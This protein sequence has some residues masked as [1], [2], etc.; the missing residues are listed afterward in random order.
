[1]VRLHIT[2]ALVWHRMCT[3]TQLQLLVQLGTPVR[4]PP[5]APGIVSPLLGSIYRRGQSLSWKQIGSDLDSSMHLLLD[6]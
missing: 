6:Y 1:M 2:D 3:V 5:V 4:D